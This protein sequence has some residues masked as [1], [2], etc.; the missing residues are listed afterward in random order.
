MNLKLPRKLLITSGIM[1]LAGVAIISILIL[2]GPQISYPFQPVP[3]QL[4]LMAGAPVTYWLTQE[5]QL[6]VKS[7]EGSFELKAYVI[8]GLKFYLFYALQ[9]EPT[10]L[11]LVEAFSSAGANFTQPMP[12]P[13]S[14]VTV[15]PNPTPDVSKA[16]PLKV[17]SIQSIGR[18]EQAELG[19]IV[20]EL[21]DQPGQL[22]SLRITPLGSGGTKPAWELTP[23]K[24]NNLVKDSQSTVS[25]SLQN[26][27]QQSPTYSNV[28]IEM[29]TA[30][31]ENQL[32]IFKIFLP[33]T[34][35]Q[36]LYYRLDQQGKLSSFTTA[37]C[38]KMFPPRPTLP[39]GQDFGPVTSTPAVPA[40]CN[41]NS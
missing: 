1:L 2:S 4:A 10:G 16:K 11:P 9:A 3:E 28:R 29:L 15:T 39:P 5:D 7:P 37:E 23:F 8:S 26:L 31:G 30:G 12:K 24:Q 36:P 35:I 34:T 14:G 17:N 6:S 25:G 32:A 22:L 21:P 19:M 40:P 33:E 41:A 38:N 13:D 27:Y 20:L 18:L